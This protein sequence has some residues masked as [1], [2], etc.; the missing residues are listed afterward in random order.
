MLL[1][2]RH[3]RFGVVEED[4]SELQPSEHVERGFLVASG[5][6]VEARPEP[7]EGHVVDLAPTMLHLLGSRIPKE[8]DGRPL[9]LAPGV[10]PPVRA[11]IDMDDD[12]W[13]ER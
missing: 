12:P 6:A 10:E 3:P 5:P 2:V 13:R 9:P 4:L 11:A 1:R 7:I 8:M